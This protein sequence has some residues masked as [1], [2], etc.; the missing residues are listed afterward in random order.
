[1]G[2]VLYRQYSNHDCGIACIRM[3]L[4]HYG[5]KCRHEE[6]EQMCEMDN[7][8]L[9]LLDISSCF[10]QLGFATKSLVTSIQQLQHIPV[11]FILY[12]KESH[13]VVIYKTDT[14]K[15][16]VHIADPAF[17]KT[18]VSIEQLYKYVSDGTRIIVMVAVP[19]KRIDTGEISSSCVKGKRD[20]FLCKY[21][22]LLFNNKMEYSFS[23]LLLCV[24]SL[25][26]WI[27]P[28]I[29]QRIV[30]TG[31]LKHDFGQV[32]LLLLFQFLFYLG[33]LASNTVSRFLI[34]KVNFRISVSLLTEYLLKLLQTPLKKFD[35]NLKTDYIQRLDDQNTIQDFST[36]HL[37][38]MI[39]NSLNVIVFASAL[40]HYSAISL[41]LF[42][43]LSVISAGIM[44]LLWYKRKLIN[45]QRFY[46]SSENQNS[47]LEIIGGIK[48]IKINGADNVQISKW[49]LLRNRL[50]EVAIK[51]IYINNIQTIS[52]SL[53]HILRDVLISLYASYLT[54]NN[55]LTIGIFMSIS[56]IMGN[57]SVSVNQI[58]NDLSLFQNALLASKRLSHI[59]DSTEVLHEN[60]GSVLSTERD[61]L[62]KSLS[63]KY[64]NKDQNF[65][66]QDINACIPTGKVTA[67]VGSSGCGKTTLIK[68]LLS[69][70]QPQNGQIIIGTTPLEEIDKKLW[71][72]SIGVVLQDGY[73]FSGSFSENIA[74]GDAHPD[75]G[76]VKKAAQIAC[77]DEFINKLPLDYKTQIGNQGVELS[78]GQKQR[79]LIARAVYKDPSVIILD[80]ATSFL[81]ATNESRIYEN[82]KGFFKGKTVITVAHRLSTVRQADQI[83]VMHAGSI[84]EWGNHEELISKKGY[85][86]E[87]VKNQIS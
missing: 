76:R 81:D 28:F 67:I 16:T 80:E 26:N 77:I 50:N 68:L 54:I 57:L 44:R 43:V 11:P 17:G 15:Q 8:G 75:L 45:Y 31:I 7:R 87:L 18:V 25:S 19:T 74:L 2:F 78:M 62:I 27:I 32:K 29:L 79:V 37:I 35:A 24:L 49:K 42:V 65:V 9:S 38:D 1:M 20:G 63:F 3:I 22:H 52:T 36:S 13:F 56:F 4:F 34:Q 86:Y 33:F 12:L 60:K 14:L 84:V 61:I 72:A 46:L 21:V 5:V 55:E 85:Y 73:I 51:G 40:C 64:Q 39:I 82:F 70:Y 10:K 47:V 48:D 30:D 83:L 69:L 58:I 71:Y 41:L 23:L 59:L 66:L 6:I 53:I